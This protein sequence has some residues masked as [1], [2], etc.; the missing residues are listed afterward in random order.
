ML[1]LSDC[2]L[3]LRFT[4]FPTSKNFQYMAPFSDTNPIG[5]GIPFVRAFYNSLGSYGI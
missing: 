4:Y 5:L 2:E 1:L 3:N